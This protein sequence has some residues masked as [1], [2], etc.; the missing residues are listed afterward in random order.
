[1]Y[2][3]DYLE[4]NAIAIRF[5]SKEEHQKILEIFEDTQHMVCDSGICSIHWIPHEGNSRGYTCE[6]GIRADSYY[7][8]RNNGYKVITFKELIEGPPEPVYRFF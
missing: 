6:N 1:M 7:R 8:N 5:T 2:T 3:L 4:K